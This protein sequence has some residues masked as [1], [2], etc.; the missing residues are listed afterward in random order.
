MDLSLEEGLEL[1]EGLFMLL[2]A[3]RLMLL[4]LALG[5]GLL[6]VVAGREGMGRAA[7]LAPP[8]TGLLWAKATMTKVKAKPRANG[9]RNC[10]FFIC[11]LFD[12]KV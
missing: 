7:G 11:C 2:G 3:G 5:M 4:G 1:V 6:G 8:A 12:A 9:F 10:R